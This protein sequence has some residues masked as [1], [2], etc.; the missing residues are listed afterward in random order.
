[1]HSVAWSIFVL[2]ALALAGCFIVLVGAVWLLFS[3]SLI[4][5]IGYTT[6]GLFLLVLVV[7][8]VSLI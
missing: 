6:V 4:E 2:S 8:L 1:M 3:T 7:T 5:A